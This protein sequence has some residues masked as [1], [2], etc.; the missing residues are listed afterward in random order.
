M[1][2]YPTFKQAIWLLLLLASVE[3]ACTI[4][5]SIVHTQVRVDRPSKPELALIVGTAVG[6][7]VIWWGWRKTGARFRSVFP[8]SRIRT[9]LLIPV[10]L[11]VIGGGIVI[12]E[13]DNL[14]RTILPVPESLVQA[15]S[16]VGG[17]T[18]SIFLILG[19]VLSAS[20]LEE[21]L[22]RG[23]ILYGF[24][25]NYPLNKALVCS[26]LL[27]GFLH[28]NPWQFVGSFI[29]GIVFGWWFT[30]TQSLW[31]CL[32][33]HSLNNSIAAIFSHFELPGLITIADFMQPVEFQPWWLDLS[34][35]LLM[36]LGLWWF[37]RASNSRKPD[38][39]GH[40]DIERHKG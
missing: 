24:L 3:I 34:G 4:I 22:F 27:F 17:D 15:L 5:V 30:R 28:M 6:C 11:T 16:I 8:L 19:P 23:L 13:I 37:S 12:S 21:G 26:A 39:I 31:P 2:N 40:P 29:M 1:K 10:F 25:R 9:V 7:F 35:L 38:G 14:V 20:V 18:S 36:I 33:G 32:V